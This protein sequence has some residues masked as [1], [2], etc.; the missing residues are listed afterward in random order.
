[1]AGS[2]ETLQPSIEKGQVVPP[3]VEALLAAGKALPSVAEPQKKEI[4]EAQKEEPQ[5]EMSLTDSPIPPKGLEVATI[6]ELAE[7][8][9]IGVRTFQRKVQSMRTE[10]KS[11][12][13]KF[14][15]GEKSAYPQANLVAIAEGILRKDQEKQRKAVPITVAQKE[16]IEKNLHLVAGIVQKYFSP[17]ERL[18]VDLIEEGNIGLIE[19]AQKFDHRRG[20]EF[21]TYATIRIRGQILEALRQRDL[22]PRP[23]RQRVKQLEKA[24][25]ELTG[26]LGG[27]PTDEQLASHLGLSPNQLRQAKQDANLK[28]WSMD[29]PAPSKNDENYSLHDILRAPEELE[30][31]SL[32]EKNELYET[33]RAAFDQLPDRQKVLLSCYYYEEFTMKEI[34]KILS[35]SE[36]RVSQLHSQAIFDLR[37]LL[38][39][40]GIVVPAL[41]SRVGVF[42]RNRSSAATRVPAGQL[43]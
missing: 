33:V 34:G 42:S 8:Y 13:P 3:E 28:I 40:K 41:E 7:E 43:R 39:D 27:R 35:I 22:L 25:I 1:M 29:A 24:I 16:L 30:P 12:C 9:G 23:T 19:A 18:S 2:K 26:T 15:A 36:R 32:K 20:V 4:E 14:F 21:V 31:A 37:S 17:E 11:S 5:M 38:R 6:K 10:D